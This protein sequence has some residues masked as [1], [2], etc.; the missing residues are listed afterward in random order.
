MDN[1]V[2]KQHRN[3]MRLENYDYTAP[4]AYYVTLATYHR[5]KLFGNIE[6][7]III[8]ND[9]AGA[10]HEVSRNRRQGSPLCENKY[11]GGNATSLGVI[12]GSFKSAVTKQIHQ[13][14]L[15]N[16]KNIWQ[17]HYYDH[18]IRND[19]DYQRIV[20]YIDMNPSNWEQD[21]EYIPE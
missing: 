8:I 6:N 4:N 2:N 21:A 11:I 5:E 3:K 15:V 7:G 10:S 20:D 19:D 1:P 16:Q 14:N 18:I 13:L 9:P 17:R 12:I